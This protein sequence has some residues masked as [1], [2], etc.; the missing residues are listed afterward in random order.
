MRKKHC[1]IKWK[2]MFMLLGLH[3]RICVIVAVPWLGLM[4]RVIIYVVCVC[5]YVCVLRAVP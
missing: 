4:L 3:Q 1:N 2:V 5:V